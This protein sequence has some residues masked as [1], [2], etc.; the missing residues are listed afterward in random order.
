MDLLQ[1]QAGYLCRTVT[2]GRVWLKHF[3]LSLNVDDT[4]LGQLPLL[5]ANAVQATESP[6]KSEVGFTGGRRG[7]GNR[8]DSQPSPEEFVGRPGTAIKIRWRKRCE[9]QSQE[10]SV[11]LDSTLPNN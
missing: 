11:A 6:V 8:S 5:S 4:I 10:Q 3:S 1:P 9:L 7:I 2:S